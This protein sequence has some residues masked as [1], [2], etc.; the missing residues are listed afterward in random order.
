M[1]S[2]LG[3]SAVELDVPLG[4]DG[5]GSAVRLAIR[6]GD[7]LLAAA[8]P[9]GLSARNVLAGTVV[10]V[11]R[12]DVTLIVRVDCGVNFDAYLTP[13]AR[14]SLNIEPGKQ[15]WLVIKTYSCH[16]LRRSPS[17]DSEET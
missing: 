8:R 7:I 12:R 3:E 15:V 9:E 14:D 13:G 4:R 17:D 10:S 5:V 16:L 11:T 6:A 1:T 2:R